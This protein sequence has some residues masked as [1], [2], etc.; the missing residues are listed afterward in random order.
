[1]LNRDRSLFPYH[2]DINNCDFELPVAEVT[3][4]PKL[5]TQWGLKNMGKQKWVMTLPDTSVHDIEPG[6]SV[7]LSKGKKINFGNIEGEIYA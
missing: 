7:I 1:M 4:N 5:L 3:R 6:R 2:L